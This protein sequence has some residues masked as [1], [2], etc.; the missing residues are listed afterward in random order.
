MTSPPDEET[1]ED[2]SAVILGALGVLAHD[3]RDRDARTLLA[4]SLVLVPAGDSE[5]LKLTLPVTDHTVFVF[6]SEARMARFLPD[7]Q[8]Y[9]LVPLGMLPAHW[10]EGGRSLTI[11]PGS[12]DTL[13]LSAEGVR[14]LLGRP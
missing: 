12:P 6:T 8:C 7:V 2:T 10:P 14:V 5:T 9:H 11:D 3:G 13:T 4:D 1:T